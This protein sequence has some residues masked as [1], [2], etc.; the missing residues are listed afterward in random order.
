MI[1]A[2]KFIFAL[3]FMV[4]LAACG[5]DDDVNES[6]VGTWV[7]KSLDVTLESTTDAGGTTIESNSTLTGSNLDYTLEL[8]DDDTFTTSGGYD[9]ESNTTI[10][11]FPSTNQTFS[12]SNVSG[13]GTYTDNGGSVTI[14]GAL[15]VFEVD[16][17]E[18]GEG[19]GP[20][21]TDY[22]F[23]SDGDLVFTQDE[24]TTQTISGSTISTKLMSTS[25]WERQ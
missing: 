3:S 10:T 8:K 17:V 14:D 16:G 4:L 25:V 15:Y 2:T 1:K 24:E 6:L 19:S 21:T 22:S 7:V 13:N 20:Q 23:N 18:Y 11:G 9:I 12:Y 5:D